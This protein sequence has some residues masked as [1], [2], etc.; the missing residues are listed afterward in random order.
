M[1][2]TY[3]QY[4]IG[5]LQNAVMFK[6]PNNQYVKTVKNILQESVSIEKNQVVIDKSSIVQTLVRIVD[7][8]YK[9]QQI[10]EED[11]NKLI[12]DANIQLENSINQYIALHGEMTGLFSRVGFEPNTEHDIVKNLQGFEEFIFKQQ[13]DLADMELELYNLK[14]DSE[15][16]QK[17]MNQNIETIQQ[18]EF[19]K[20][21]LSEQIQ[22]SNE[23]LQ[24][25]GAEVES[26]SNKLEEVT[27]EREAK[28][29]T[30][31]ELE[32]ALLQ[33]KG[34][35]E[36]SSQEHQAQLRE[37][38]EKTT[39]E[40]EVLQQQLSTSEEE[41]KA[42]KSQLEASKAELEESRQKLEGEVQGLKDQISVLNQLVAE[43]DVDIANLSDQLRQLIAQ[44]QQ[45]ISGQQ[46]K[47]EQ[48]VIS[49]YLSYA[50]VDTDVDETIILEKSPK[51]KLKLNLAQSKL[52]SQVNQNE[53]K[54][55]IGSFK[56]D[57][58]ELSKFQQ[59]QTKMGEMLNKLETTKETRN[60]FTIVAKIENCRY[61]SQTATSRT[62][63]MI[64]NEYIFIL[65]C[66]QINNLLP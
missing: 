52:Q 2:L 65:R 25:I 59:M 62:T 54:I 32:A 38:T 1:S 40:K 17:Q 24:N 26:I 16:R 28:A 48:E 36:Q 66:Y 7:I 50:S 22:Y 39:V 64:Q 6:T 55:D 41:L 53:L 11:Q 63:Q 31:V 42:I 9:Q 5:M 47:Q 27:Q 60:N 44:N 46:N 20:Q 49:Q 14:Q 51:P 3:D 37:V 30:V 18:L 8:L 4:V 35:L 12:D 58:S 34:S 10:R 43:K 45:L 23:Q 57:T 15:L 13:E 61:Q 56:I 19:E 33:L 29:A 21:M